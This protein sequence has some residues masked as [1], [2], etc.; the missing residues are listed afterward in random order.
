MS[1][2]GPFVRNCEELWRTNGSTLATHANG[3][4]TNAGGAGRHSPTSSPAVN[5]NGSYLPS[6]VLSASIAAAAAAPAAIPS[7]LAGAVGNVCERVGI[8]GVE[9]IED[10][11]R[12]RRHE[13]A[14]ESDEHVVR[15][16]RNR[17]LLR[18]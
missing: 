12:Q 7:V 9:S 14:S 18:C 13:P 8:E 11:L 2:R 15:G 16:G 17:G 1:A 3:S 5:E 10:H 4:L 6:F